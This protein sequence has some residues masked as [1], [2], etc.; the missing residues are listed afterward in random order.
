MSIR[1]IE[2]LV[3]DGVLIRTLL[4]FRRYGGPWAIAMT[5]R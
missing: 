3:G 1:V 4:G 5:A 2:V